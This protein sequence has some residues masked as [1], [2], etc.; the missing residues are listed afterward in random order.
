MTVMLPVVASFTYATTEPLGV[1]VP[2]SLSDFDAALA[3]PGAIT[4]TVAAAAVTPAPRM[5]A[6][7]QRFKDV[8]QARGTALQGRLEPLVRNMDAQAFA[9]MKATKTIYELTDAEKGEWKVIFDKVAA[10]LRGSV[11]TPALFDRVEKLAHE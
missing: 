3:T 2:S 11:F 5:K 1:G 4:A 9:R 7:P 8:M 6:L 10:Q